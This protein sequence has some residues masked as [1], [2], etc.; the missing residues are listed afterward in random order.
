[1]EKTT[2]PLSKG[3]TY[4]DADGKIKSQNPNGILTALATNLQQKLNLDDQKNSII[5]GAFF[6]KKDDGDL[7]LKSFK[8]EEIGDISNRKRAKEIVMRCARFNILKNEIEKNESNAQAAKDY[9]IKSMLI[10]GSNARN[11]G[12]IITDDKGK[13]I[14]LKHNKAFELISNDKSPTFEFSESSVKITGGGVSVVY[15]Q[16]RT[17]D[18]ET[19]SK[20]SITKESLQNPELLGDIKT[21]QNDSTFREYITGHMKLLETIL[22]QTM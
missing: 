5:T 12:Q 19:R 3:K 16:E 4:I 1:M 6:D 22:N 7:I 8:G 11:M 13:M 10:C 9:L 14:V 2:E 21:Q 20:C 15:G 17:G 18:G